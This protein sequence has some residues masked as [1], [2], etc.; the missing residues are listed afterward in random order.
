MFWTQRKIGQKARED[1]CQGRVANSQ[2]LQRHQITLLAILP[3]LAIEERTIGKSQIEPHDDDPTHDSVD[4]LAII[5]ER[6]HMCL[7]HHRLQ[8]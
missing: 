7:A 2:P 3:W 4:S 8:W 1:L 6:N 5:G